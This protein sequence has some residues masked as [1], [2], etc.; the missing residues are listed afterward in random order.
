V[1]NLN[2]LSIVVPV[3]YNEGSLWPTYQDIKTGIIDQETYECEII[4][5]DDGSG[6]NSWDVICQIQAQD[7]HIKKVKLSR[8]FGS[9]YAVLCGLKKSTGDCVVIKA[10]DQQE[11]IQLIIDMV[12]KWREGY[13]VVLAERVGR[14]E[15]FTTKLFSNTYYSLV[16]R[17]AFAKMPKYGFDIFLLDRKACNVICAMDEKNSSTICQVLW[18]GFRST[19]VP[20]IRLARKVGKSKWSFKNKFRLV[21]DT[22]YNYSVLPCK[23]V[24]ILGFLF[25]VV[26]MLWGLWLI[27]ARLNNK[28]ELSGWTT[29]VV[30]QLFC[31]GMTMLILSILGGYLWRLFIRTSNRPSFI[32]EEDIDE[33]VDERTL[34]IDYYDEDS[35]IP[36]ELR[37][38]L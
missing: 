3:Y 31:F 27:I 30:L 15:P 22:F 20:Y 2:K 13:N 35:L 9:Q 36:N 16:R 11:P 19:T 23:V 12:A 1:R 21:E 25:T 17:L 32:I 14:D 37:R 34:S 6:D 18:I 5:V 26:S 29:V 8:N 10:A 7:K 33:S 38:F 24:S 4:F 28:I